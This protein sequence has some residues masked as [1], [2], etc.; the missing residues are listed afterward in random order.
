M[1]SERGWKVDDVYHNI[2]MKSQR[3]WWGTEG[4]GGQ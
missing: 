1:V 4:L 3:V 2:E